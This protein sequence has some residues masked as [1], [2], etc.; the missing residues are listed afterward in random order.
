MAR[1]DEEHPHSGRGVIP[2]AAMADLCAREYGA[3]PAMR[4][5]SPSGAGYDT[6]SHEAFAETVRALSRR[7]A[8]RGLPR[9]GRVAVLGENR[10][11][12]VA[13]YLATIAAGGVIVP[14]D[15]SMQRSAVRHILAESEARILFVSGRHRSVLDEM[16]PVRSLVEIVDMDDG[17]GA[18]AWSEL[19]REGMD[20]GAP[21]LPPTDPNDPAIILYTSG[22][23]GHGKGVVLS[24]NN[25]ASNVAAAARVLDLG[26]ADVFLSVL[27]I[28]HAYEM[29]AGIL[30]PL[31]CGSSI[32]FARSMKSADLVADMRDTGVTVLVG[33]PLLFE[34]LRDGVRRG[35]ARRGRAARAYFRLNAGLSAAGERLGRDWGAPL[36][37]P[38]RRAAG[39]EG[40]RYFVSGGAPLDP[41]VSLFFDR[42]GI[43]LLQGYGLTEASPL[44]HVNRPD[45]KGRGTVGPPIDGVECRILDMDE[46]GVGE[47]CVR[48]PNVFLGYHGDPEG[49][50]AVL[51]ADGW[52]RTGDMGRIDAEHRLT[53]TGRRKN[54]IVTPGGKNVY[55]EE[56]EMHLNRSP[57]IA[58]S[59][60]I[61]VRRD[62]GYGEDP[63]ALIHPDYEKIDLHF[64]EA[65]RRADDRD[66]AALLRAEIERRQRGLETFKRV[67]RFRVVE[68][69]FA[70]TTTRKIK[71]YLYDGET[72]HTM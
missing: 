60:V 39:F 34:K 33:V 43:R 4:V 29:M 69:E 18:E 20:S 27:P 38:F 19:V 64:E 22:T 41:T 14:V 36:F 23:T 50:A 61:G 6:I 42:I 15:R 35:V 3:R 21:P 7:L 54:V 1:R 59:L 48:G 70:K 65:G 2:L 9:G 66:V 25:I 46:E 62:A 51:G 45:R 12:W 68:E 72:F 13:A 5:R 67:R 55:P 30:L 17:P 31:Y 16:E 10:P 47:I 57:L 26:A 32:T 63:A 28:H 58:E 52:L 44:T 37:R 49:T 56:V 71:R 24:Q 40:T 53:I 8:A 11:E